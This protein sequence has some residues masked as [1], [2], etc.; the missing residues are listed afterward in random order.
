MGSRHTRISLEIEEIR[1]R[2]RNSFAMKNILSFFLICCLIGNAFAVE[3]LQIGPN[4]AK[5]HVLETLNN[6]GFR[7]IFDYVSD[8]TPQNAA[9]RA[10]VIAALQQKVT[11]DRK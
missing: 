6:V 11:D 3:D 8:T 7:N 10:L 9:R 4:F 2:H 1:E 5:K